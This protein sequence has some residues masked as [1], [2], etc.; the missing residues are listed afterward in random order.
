MFEHLLLSVVHRPSWPPFSHDHLPAPPIEAWDTTATEDGDWNGNGNGDED[1][2]EAVATTTQ[3]SFA[4]NGRW[5]YKW[6]I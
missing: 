4:S 6:K 3:A 2:D 5:Q 1:E